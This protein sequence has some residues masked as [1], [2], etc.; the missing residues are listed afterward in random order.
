MASHEDCLR[1][2]IV[3]KECVHVWG[4]GGVVSEQL[5]TALERSQVDTALK[6]VLPEGSQAKAVGSGLGATHLD[7]EEK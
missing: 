2:I 4:G 5:Y 3:D 1:C 7:K 6:L